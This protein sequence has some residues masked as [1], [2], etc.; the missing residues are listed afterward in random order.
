MKFQD[1]SV[2]DQKLVNMAFPA[3]IEKE[4]SENVTLIQELHEYGFSKLAMS[5]ANDL[6]KAASEEKEEEEEEEDK[7]EKKEASA[8]AFYITEG[9][10]EGLKKLGSDRYG[11]ENIYLDVFVQEKVADWKSEAAAKGKKAWGSV[12]GYHKDIAEDTKRVLTGKRTGTYG[13]S[14]LPVEG[15]ER[16]MAGLK[17]MGRSTPHAA[18]AGLGAW[19]AHKALKKDKKD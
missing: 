11:D 19:G 8:R 18:V 17:A 16:A 14:S 12:K 3:E 10:I 2:E 13:P 6:E 7:D 15:R 5:V 9:L 1:L 4:A